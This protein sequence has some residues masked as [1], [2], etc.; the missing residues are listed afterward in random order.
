METEVEVK[1]GRPKKISVEDVA[2]VSNEARAEHI[3]KDP[4]SIYGFTKE[5]DRMVSGVFRNIQHPGQHLRF[6]VRLYKGQPLK[7]YHMEDGMM[8][9][10]PLS[11]AK[12]LNRNCFY[13]IYDSQIITDVHGRAM[14]KVKQMVQR[15]QFVSSELM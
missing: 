14:P 7:T 12:H 4:E 3:Q 5:T 10:I 1:R 9:T 2:Q 6:S 13:P 15:F 11:V 8:Y